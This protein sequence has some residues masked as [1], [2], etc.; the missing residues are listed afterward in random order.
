MLSEKMMK[1]TYENQ[2]EAKNIS[3]LAFKNAIDEKEHQCV[4]VI[5]KDKILIHYILDI[6]K[7]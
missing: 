1:K 3:D 2:A 4:F 5:F 7:Y 6:I